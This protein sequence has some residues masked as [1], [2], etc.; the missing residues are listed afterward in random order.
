MSEGLYILLMSL[1]FAGV[2]F[3]TETLISQ[4]AK[5]RPVIS[6]LYRFASRLNS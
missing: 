4:A 3:G 5:W 6:K 1:Y 2:F